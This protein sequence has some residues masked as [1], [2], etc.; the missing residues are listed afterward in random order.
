VIHEF[1]ENLILT[2]RSEKPKAEAK[3]TSTVFVNSYFEVIM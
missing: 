1:N 3:G 2:P